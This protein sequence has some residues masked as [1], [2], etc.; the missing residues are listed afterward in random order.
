MVVMGMSGSTDSERSYL[1]I[2]NIGQL[3]S[4]E[5]SITEQRAG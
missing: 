1:R 3:M 5:S 4:Y 2:E